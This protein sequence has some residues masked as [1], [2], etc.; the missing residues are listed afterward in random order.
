MHSGKDADKF[1]TTSS[2]VVKIVDTVVHDS[3][4]L[5]A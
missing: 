1:D 4:V 5:E 2:D 3:F